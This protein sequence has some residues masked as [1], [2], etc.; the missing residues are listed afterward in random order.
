MGDNKRQHDARGIISLL[1][2]FVMTPF[3]NIIG[4]PSEWCMFSIVINCSLKRR[5]QSRL[6]SQRSVPG[7]CS[8]GFP[9]TT[10]YS[11]LRHSWR[12]GIVY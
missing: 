10:N 8:P 1:V 2:D 7:L 3:F 6:L 11:I 5:S 4:L 9:V 12:G